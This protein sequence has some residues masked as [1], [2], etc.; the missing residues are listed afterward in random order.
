MFEEIR[1]ICRGSGLRTFVLLAAVAALAVLWQGTRDAGAQSLT[2]QDLTGELELQNLAESLVGAGGGVAISNVTYTGDDSA[3]GVF[4]GGGGIVGFDTGVLLSSGRVQDVAGTNTVSN[5]SSSLGQPGDEDLTPLSEF[6]TSDA[7]VLEFDFVPNTNLVTFDYVFA[8]EEYNEYV[9]SM[10]NDVFAFFVNDTNCAVVPNPANPVASL[11]V[12][13]NTINNGDSNTP[14][15]N[16]GLY[17]NNDPF[18]A[19]SSGSTVPQGSLRETQMDGLTHVLTCAAP[20]NPGATNHVKL[21]IADAS[22]SSFDSAVFIKG[23][24]FVSAQGRVSGRVLGPVQ[25]SDPPALTVLEGAMVT[26]CAAPPCATNMTDPLGGFVVNDLPAGDYHIIAYPPPSRNDLLPA[27]MAITLAPGESMDVGDMVMDFAVAPPQGVTIDSIG[28]INGVPVIAWD[29]STGFSVPGCEGGTASYRL[30]ASNGTVLA[31]GSMSES[32]PGTYN[33]TIPPL[34]PYHG[35]GRIEVDIECPGGG[36]EDVDFDV[37]IDPSGVVKTVG[38]DPISGA[39]VTL[40]RSDDADGPFETV[41]DGSA[42]MSPSNRNNPDTTN[43]DGQFHWDVVAGYYKVRAEKAGC[44][45]PGNPAQAFVETGVMEIPP[46]VTNLDL[47]L[48]CGGGASGGFGDV[49]CDGAVD[50]VDALQV[51][52]SVANLT[53]NS[54]CDTQIGTGD[55]LL[56]DV[57]C[58]GGVDAVDALALLRHVANLPVQQEQGC[59]VIGSA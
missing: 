40:Y 22:D 14:P 35:P 56:G 49:N 10:F 8:S 15:T 4:S 45:A 52:R 27:D 58:S 59:P 31:S 11:P 36:H 23:G 24:S 1:G 21:A 50:A 13:I 38:G 42:V 16:P 2:V 20:V 32:P 41:P 33:G 47:R 44:N 39:T 5:F 43:A 46:P 53:V 6:P 9:G 51:L 57:N 12:S 54:S 30:L 26:V 19:D 55:P 48:D 17:I 29:K 25:G 3:G 34:S 28:T 7:A 18:N 37:Y